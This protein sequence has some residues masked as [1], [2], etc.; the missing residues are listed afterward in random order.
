MKPI[1]ARRLRTRQRLIDAASL[2]I[3]ER[4]LEG[5][6]LDEI[7]TRVGLTKGAIYDNFESK[8]DLILA[9]IMAKAAQ[10]RRPRFEAAGTLKEHLQ[11]IGQVVADFLPAAEAQAGPSAQLDLYA[12]THDSMR[13]KLSGFYSARIAQTEVMMTELAKEH[14]LPLPPAQFAVLLSVLAAGLVQHRLMTP[15]LVPDEFIIQAF[16]A[17]APDA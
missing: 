12:L 6:T 13:A 10:P 4:G 16:E 11:Q 7:A 17:L 8:D 14:A 9:V 1:S 3:A 15:H 2:V 5:A